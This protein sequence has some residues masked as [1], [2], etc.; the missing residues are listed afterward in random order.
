MFVHQDVNLL[1]NTWLK[2]AEEMLDT[3]PNLGIAGVVGSVEEGDS[4]LERM[5]NVIAHGDD[6]EQI[7]NPISSPERVQTL[8]E[9][10]LIVPREVFL[11]YQFDETTCSNC[12]CTGWIIALP[13]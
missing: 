9:M 11:E 12:T 2:D 10:L 7:G 5:R 1:S 3:I 4:V 13:C 8:D 6:R